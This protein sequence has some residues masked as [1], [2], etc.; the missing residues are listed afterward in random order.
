MPTMKMEMR[1]L[2]AQYTKDIRSQKMARA[3]AHVYDH[4]YRA[5]RSACP[6]VEPAS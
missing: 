2:P 4:Y 6:T 5:G 1:R 3:C